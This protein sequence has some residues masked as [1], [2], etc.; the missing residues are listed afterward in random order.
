MV[1]RSW[2]DAPEGRDRGSPASTEAFLVYHAEIT[3]ELERHSI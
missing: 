2:N 3:C 1:N